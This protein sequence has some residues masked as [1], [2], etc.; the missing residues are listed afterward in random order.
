VA[1]GKP[2]NRCSPEEVHAFWT[3]EA[4][5]HG[6]S[7]SA[8]WSDHPM[9]E[10]EIQ[11]IGPHVAGERTLD[12]GCANG[13]SSIRFAGDYGGHVLGVDYVEEM[14]SNAQERRAQLSRPLRDRVEFRVGD[15]RALDLEDDSFDRVV[16]TRVMINLSGWEEQ[17][18]G[19][20]E[21]LRVLRPGGLLL[22]S[23]AT[24][25]G[26]SRLNALRKEWGL[27]GI[28]MPPFNSYLEES[29]VIELLSPRADL[30]A[31]E[32]FASSYYVA[33]RFL[34][35]LLARGYDGGVSVD[36]AD[37]QAEFNR[38]ASRLPA[39]GDYGTQKLAHP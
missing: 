3:G 33:T 35:P 36:V 6:L 1:D 32:D 37:P 31:V 4:A 25:G 11:T 26:W 39:A 7:P 30:V 27:E 24:V 5:R 9:I 23:E 34:K 28:P 8:S 17:A 22:L 13:Y 38:W 29:K 12:V 19:L 14:I 21:C 10:L 15:A 2:T 16:S 18:A 20:G